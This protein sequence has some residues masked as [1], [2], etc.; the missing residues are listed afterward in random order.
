MT[1]YL[2]RR[3]LGAVGV[4]FGVATISFIMIFLMPGDAARMYAGPRAPEETVQRI[5]VLW[6]LDQP[7]PVQYVRYLGR[8][9]Q[10]DLGNSTRDNRPVLRA[11]LERLPATIQLALAGL[12]VELAFGLPLG[13]VAALRPGSWID[14][15][16]T[17]V[18]LI[19]I[20]IPSFALGLVALYLFGYLIPIFPLGGYGTPLHL[21]LPALTLGLGGTAFYARVLRGSLLEVMGED[22]IRT[23]NAKGLR[24]HT[25]LLRHTLR[26]ALLPLVTLAA[27]DLALLLGG[28]VV[29]E[30]VFGWPGVG[31]QA[32]NAIR[33]QDTPMI[34]GTVL[35]ASLSVVVINLLVDLLYLVLDPRVRLSG[36][37]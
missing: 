23:A 10:G 13:I 18:S 32:F 15:L 12:C 22:Y 30:A 7:L 19:G 36:R 21:V 14:Q 27:F 25:V 17:V 1:A 3:L 16:A 9:L 8:A 37:R 20:S 26:N 6:G 29:I 31:L 2:V 5:R 24:S 28:T 33:N 11:V 4:V 34:M 35:F